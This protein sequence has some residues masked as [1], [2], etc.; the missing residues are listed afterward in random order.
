MRFVKAAALK[1]MQS[2]LFCSRAWL[3]A[4]IHTA[5]PPLST[6]FASILASIVEGGVVIAASDGPAELHRSFSTVPIRPVFIPFR[7]KICLVM[8]FTVV[9]PFVPVTAKHCSFSE[10]LPNLT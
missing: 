8:L 1:L 3:L 6:I 2:S 4:S 9:F 10:G 7:V 5:F